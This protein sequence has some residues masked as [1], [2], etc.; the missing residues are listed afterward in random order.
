MRRVKVTRT[1]IFQKGK[2]K[3]IETYEISEKTA[4]TYRGKERFHRNK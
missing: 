2:V 3:N 1:K 4:E